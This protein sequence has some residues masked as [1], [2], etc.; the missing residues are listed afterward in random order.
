MGIEIGNEN[1]NV[2][3]YETN[4]GTPIDSVFS[5]SSLPL[6]QKTNLWVLIQQY[7]KK[8]IKQMEQIT[9]KIGKQFLMIFPSCKSNNLALGPFSKYPIYG[10]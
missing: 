10:F 6:I 8:K 3:G 2:E 5:C 7:P 4:S 1:W 9:I